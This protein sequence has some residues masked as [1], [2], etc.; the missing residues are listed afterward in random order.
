MAYFLVILSSLF[1]GG[2]YVLGKYLVVSAPSLTL[3]SLRWAVAV[4]VLIPVVLVREKHWW[5][6]HKAWPSLIIMGLTGAFLF[7]FFLF[8]AIR[9]TSSDDA[10]LISTLNPV[11]I[12][13]IAYFVLK[14]RLNGKQALAMALSFLGVLIVISKGRWR[15]LSSM[16]INP[17]DGY[18]LLSV[19]AWGIYSV[20][21][22]VAMR[23]VSPL[24]ATLWMGII[25]LIVTVPVNLATGLQLQHPSAL[26]WWSALYVGVLSTVLAMVFWNIGVK[27]VGATI[28]GIFLN[29]TVIFTAIL[30]YVLLGETL[31]VTQSFGMVIVIAGVTLFSLLR[32]RTPALRDGQL[33]RPQ[34]D[35]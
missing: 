18:M 5:P 2:N 7:N 23:Y 29:F 15:V 32:T 3:T 6:P 22:R 30:A 10:A 28:S 4:I 11:V 20:A 16:N 24:L 17:G 9:R 35:P 25:S 33:A 1:W 14:T 27:Q 21:G 34:K 8:M 26:F 19:L 31:T 12:A 13:I